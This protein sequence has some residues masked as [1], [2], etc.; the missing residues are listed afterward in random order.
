MQQPALH[1]ALDRLGELCAAL[2]DVAGDEARTLLG[3]LR[4]EARA[5][6]ERHRVLAERQAEAIVDAGMM[7]SELEEIHTALDR[8]RAPLPRPRARPNHSSS[9]T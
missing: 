8:A 4:A 1:H 7:V 9:R 5:A 3:E 2:P 6:T